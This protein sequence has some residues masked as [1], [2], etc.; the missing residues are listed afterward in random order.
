MITTGTVKKF[1]ELIS[2][3]EKRIIDSIKDGRVETEPS[4]TDRLM[5]QIESVFEEN[6]S[7]EGIIFKAR[8]LRDRGKNASESKFGADFCG[9]LNVDLRKFKRTKGF[10]TQA[11]IEGNGIEVKNV[12]Y[13]GLTTVSFRQNSEFR[14]LSGQLDQML[15]VTPDSF[16]IVYSEKGFV[17]VPASSVAGLKSDGVL[18]GKPLDRFFKEYLMCFIGDHRLTAYDDTSLEGLRQLTNSRTAIIFQLF[19]KTVY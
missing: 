6:S 2:E 11:K 3:A 4:I 1:G 18:Y 8:S 12:R 17:V 14:R 13:R 15:S 19:D 7:Q 5:R 9:V 16:L 10:L